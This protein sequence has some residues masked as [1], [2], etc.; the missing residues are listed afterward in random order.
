MEQS[1]FVKTFGD[2][3][4]IRVLDFLIES[5]MFDYPLTEI[6]KNAEVNFAT[7][8]KI[9]KQLEKNVIVIQTRKIGKAKLY[10]LDEENPAVQKLIELDRA[11][12]KH[13]IREELRRQKSLVTV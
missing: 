2:Y 7:L 10:K 5:R 13:A 12:S 9:W 11:L 1:T 6:A 3:P 4:L 8:K